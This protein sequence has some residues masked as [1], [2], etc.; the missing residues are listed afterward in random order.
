[1]E[2][3][4]S[5]KIFVDSCFVAR[6][7][8]ESID[9]DPVMDCHCVPCVQGTAIVPNLEIQDGMQNFRI[10][11]AQSYPETFGQAG[12]RVRVPTEISLSRC[13]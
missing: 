7:T 6:G 11:G 10:P 4:N 9:G 13:R 1:M 3:G 12:F 2:A 5:V 8:V